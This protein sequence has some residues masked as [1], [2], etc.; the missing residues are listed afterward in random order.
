MTTVL[1]CLTAGIALPYIL[2]GVSVPYRNAQMGG[3]DIE[4]PRAQ[5]YQLKEGGG[6]AR[7]AQENAWEAITAF[8]VVC[9]IAFMAGVDPSGSWATAAM[10]WG[11][12]RVLHA[13]FYVSGKGVLR[14]AAFAIGMGMNIW[15]LV[16][17]FGAA[18]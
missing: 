11:V 1:I 8:G 5:G 9:L 18:G 3:M 17:A 2:A 16:L 4:E 7:D 12:A 10:I 6:R 14:V 15:I 13:V